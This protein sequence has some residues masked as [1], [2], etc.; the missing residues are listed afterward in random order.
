VADIN[1]HLTELKVQKFKRFDSLHMSD[2]GQFNLILGDNNVG[3]TS[4]LEALLIDSDPKNTVY[5]LFGALAFRKLKSSFYYSDIEVFAGRSAD[6]YE[7]GE[8]EIVLDQVLVGDSIRIVISASRSEGNLRIGVY[9]STK[10]QEVANMDFGLQETAFFSINAP[11]S[12]PYVPFYQ[13]HDN[14]LTKYYS[15]LQENK[16]SKKKFL[17]ALRVLLPEIDNVELS[18]PYSGQGPHLIVFQSHTDNALPLAVFGDGVLKLFRFVAEIIS[19]KGRRLMIDEIDTGIHFSRMRE[20]WK[21]IL[22]TAIDNDVQ[23]FMTTHSEECVRFFK[24]VLEEEL[25]EY[26]ERARAISLV[27]HRETKK[28]T[29]HTYP[30]EQFEHAI[31]VGNEI[32]G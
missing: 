25:S 12:I 7:N 9:R 6:S 26:K 4:V 13:G 23:L 27:E 19:Q 3:K 5:R 14:D 1:H 31:N 22:E 30:F 16:S 8:F 17:K 29:A 21:V 18:S 32:R 28:V 11:W 20:F 24:E 2:L 10:G 15:K